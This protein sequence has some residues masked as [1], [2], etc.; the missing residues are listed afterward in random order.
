MAG[1]HSAAVQLGSTRRED[2]LDPNAPFYKKI[3]RVWKKISRWIGDQISRIVT[4][5]MF[6]IVLPLF[7]IG[8]RMFS[9]PLELKPSAAP[10]WVPLPPQPAKAL[11]EAR[12]GF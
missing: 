8:V 4:T 11:D 5:L 6:A 1:Q 3:W 7:A 12:N 2:P 9:D 10:H